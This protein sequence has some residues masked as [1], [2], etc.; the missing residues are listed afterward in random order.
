MMASEDSQGDFNWGKIQTVGNMYLLTVDASEFSPVEII[1][2]SS[3]NLI[4]VKAEKVREDGT[5]INNFTHKFQ[6][7]LDVDP[8]SITSTLADNGAL[9]V[10]AR[11]HPTDS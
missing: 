4:E 3:N 10:K 2:T 6:L 11:R 8:M 5:V 9:T 1:V 7:P